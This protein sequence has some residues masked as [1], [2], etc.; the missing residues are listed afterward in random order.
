MRART[1]WT[2]TERINSQLLDSVCAGHWMERVGQSSCRRVT[3]GEI[4]ALTVST[5]LGKSHYFL[6][7]VS[8]SIKWGSDSS[9]GSL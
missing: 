6:L 9:T 2:P 7:P 5:T 8:T 1:A 3:S 4:L